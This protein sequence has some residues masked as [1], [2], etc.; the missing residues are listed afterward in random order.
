MKLERVI[1]QLLHAANVYVEMWVLFLEFIYSVG[2][3]LQLATHTVLSKASWHCIRR[4]V[5]IMR[6]SKGKDE[7][8][9]AQTDSNAGSMAT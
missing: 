6:S 1:G 2:S 5:Q 3:D 4:L 9:V 8:V 7:V